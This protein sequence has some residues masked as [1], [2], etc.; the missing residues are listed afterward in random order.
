MAYSIFLKYLRRLEEFRKNSHVKIPPKSPCANFQSLGIFK[1]L[2]FIR[3][4]IFL[5][6]HPIFPAP[7]TLARYA[8]PAVGSPLGPL[9]PSRVGVFAERRIPFDFAHSGRDVFSLSRH[10][11]VG[12][13]C[14]LHPLPHASRPLPL[15]LIASGHPTPPVLQPQDAKRGLHSP[16]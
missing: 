2:I 16:P 15:L 4:E 10:Y 9:G 7:P 13:A 5:R 11:H 12:S 3:K 8:P 14:P 1:N 6:F